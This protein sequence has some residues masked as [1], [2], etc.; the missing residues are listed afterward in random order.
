MGYVLAEYMQSTDRICTY[1]GISYV[2]CTS[3]T[4]I[5]GAGGGFIKNPWTTPS[6]PTEVDTKSP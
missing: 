5:K 3:Y 2:L 1:R 4:G 6:I